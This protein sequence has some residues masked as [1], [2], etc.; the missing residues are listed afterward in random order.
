MSLD[1]YPTAEEL[2]E[3]A[4][5]DLL[6]EDRSYT[7]A[8]HR[9]M[10]HVKGLWKYADT[11]YWSEQEVSDVRGPEIEYTLHTGGWS[12][13]EEIIEALEHMKMFWALYW[14]SSRRG[15]HYVFRIAK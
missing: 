11:G 12:G 3:I 15:G 8:A 6:P 13:N 1:E 4:G 14:W 5:W 7:L 2:A 9:L 10:E